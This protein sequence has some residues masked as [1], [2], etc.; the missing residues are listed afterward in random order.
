MVPKFIMANGKL[1]RVLLHTKVV[2]EERS[3]VEFKGVQGSYVLNRGRVE[4]VPASDYEALRSPLMGLFEKRR[5]RK[6]FMY[7]CG[8]FVGVVV[9]EVLVW[10]E[11]P[12]GI[13]DASSS[14][15]TLQI[16]TLHDFTTTHPLF[17][18]QHPP[19]FHH[20]TPPIFTTT[21]PCLHHTPSHHHAPKH[22]S[23]VQD[24][25]EDNPAT[26]QGLD[27]KKLSMMDLFKYFSLEPS[28]IE[29]IGHALALYTNDAY[30]MQPALPTVLRIKLYHDSLSRYEGIT[31]PYLYPLY[32][33]GELPQVGG[34]VGE[35]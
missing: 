21:H 9:V 8:F 1:I 17:S 18:P 26:H 28:T 10:V 3:M 22:R 12:Q 5:A 33:L 6:F 35:G 25:E 11:M 29:F 20:N 19:Y 31:S 7:V 27:L 15:A 14:C 34:W 32:G 2:S 30:L 16:H 23:Y 4:K 13:I 24:Y